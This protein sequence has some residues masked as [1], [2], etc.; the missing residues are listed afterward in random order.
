[1]PASSPEKSPEEELHRKPPPAIAA[2]LGAAKR[3]A[4]PEIAIVWPA[5]TRRDAP[6]AA[7]GAG[8]GAI[9]ARRGRRFVPHTAAVTMPARLIL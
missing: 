1:M 4:C 7:N 5:I 9:Q 8:S 3:H 6:C 2:R